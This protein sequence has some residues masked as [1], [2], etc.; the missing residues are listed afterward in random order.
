M[1][2]TFKRVYYLFDYTNDK[3]LEFPAQKEAYD[4]LFALEKTGG[5]GKV[6]PHGEKFC[7]GDW[8]GC[9]SFTNT[10]DVCGADYDMNGNRLAPRSQW[11]EETGEHWTECY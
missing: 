3:T 5:R 4:A 1:A 6:R 11:G 2:V 8:F 7:C 9:D 10:C